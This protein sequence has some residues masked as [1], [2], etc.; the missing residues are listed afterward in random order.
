MRGARYV[1]GAVVLL[2]ATVVGMASFQSCSTSAMRTLYIP[3]NVKPDTI[4]PNYLR[5]VSQIKYWDR[6]S[7]ADRATN[8][9]WWNQTGAVRE[10]NDYYN[11]VVVLTFFSTSF[12]PSVD[13][14][15]ILDSLDAEDTN[16]LIIAV[17]MKEVVRGGQAVL[18]IDS[19]VQSHDLPFEVLVGTPDFG[20]TYG[21]IDRV[22]TTFV[23]DRTRRISATFEGFVTEEKLHAATVSA[24][25]AE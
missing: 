11:K 2:L 12:L 16:A 23:I 14:L 19:F 4:G 25:S 5:T 18:R 15:D 7:P 22:P 17:A 3:A 9:A 10:M 13:Q 6:I 21:G 1:I 20:F 8:F 24:E